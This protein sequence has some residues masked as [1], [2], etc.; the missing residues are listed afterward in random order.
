[1]TKEELAELVKNNWQGRSMIPISGEPLKAGQFRRI[2]SA[3]DG[4]RIVYVTKVVNE[5]RDTHYLDTVGVCALCSDNLECGTDRDFLFSR[6]KSTLPF[7]LLIQTDI[8]GLLWSVDIDLYIGKVNHLQQMKIADS[9]NELYVPL[10]SNGGLPIRGNTDPRWNWKLSELT[11]MQN[12]SKDC[13][14]SMLDG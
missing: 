4:Y 12:L 11:I 2:S 14:L 7:D 10:T 1:M 8:V 3:P 6:N 5:G 13:M 9:I